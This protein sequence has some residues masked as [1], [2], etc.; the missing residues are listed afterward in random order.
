LRAL[1]DQAE[2]SGV[3]PKA[4]EEM[5][6]GVFE[7]ATRE[8]GDVMVPAPEVVWLDAR[9]PAREALDEA[10]QR[11]HLRYPVAD[12][13]LDRLVGI[14]HFR[15]LVVAA[16]TGGEAPIGPRAQAAAII[17]VTK[18]LGALLREFRER[19]QHLAVVADEYGGIAGIV[20]LE[21][22]LEEIVGEIEDEYDLP[23]ATLTWLDDRTVAV[24]GSMTIDDFNETVG[25]RLPHDGARTMAGLVFNALGR[26]PKPGDAVTLDAPS[27][28]RGAR[29]PAHQPAARRP[30]AELIPP[31][32]IALTGGAGRWCSTAA[33]GYVLPGGAP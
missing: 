18:D 13:S 23:D 9:L 3:I 22:I 31:L 25:T 19:R 14:I 2:K 10:A 21:D 4:Q 24:A 32:L 27:L 12:G 17:P 30:A 7:F 28:G 20:A 8:A 26:R 16:Q 29:R 6:H 33:S 15:E 1:V 11:P 5:L